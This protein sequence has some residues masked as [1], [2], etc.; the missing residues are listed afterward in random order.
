MEKL[1]TKTFGHILIR[2]KNTKEIILDKKNAIHYENMAIAI[3]QALTYNVNGC[4]FELAFGNGG[5]TYA[6]NGSIEYYPSVTTGQNAQLY[7]QTY[8]VVI[9]NNFANNIA[10]NNYITVNHISGTTY[11]DIVITAVLENGEPSGQNAFDNATNSTTDGSYIFNEMG[12][13]AYYPL[14]GVTNEDDVSKT[15]TKVSRKL[16]TYCNFSP[17]EKSLN[18]QIEI[19]YTIR[20]SL[21]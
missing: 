15:S 12:I 20:I 21:T 11:V 18:R 2:D 10:G 17:V 9:N 14:S 16:L 5:S 8:A 19:I 6:G 13:L 4:F 7:N 1:D 3:G